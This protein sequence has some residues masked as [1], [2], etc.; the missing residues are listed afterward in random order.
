MISQPPSMRSLSLLQL[1]TVGA[2]LDQRADSTHKLEPDLGP[3]D[4][5]SCQEPLW[6][7]II[8]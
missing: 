1:A 3:R 8:D 6:N 2:L 4:Q 7:L 5:G